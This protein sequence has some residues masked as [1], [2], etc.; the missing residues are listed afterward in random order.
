MQG[1]IEPSVEAALLEYGIVEENGVYGIRI[2]A[3]TSKSTSTK[4]VHG[5]TPD[6]PRAIALM[7]LLWKQGVSPVN[8]EDVLL[9]MGLISS[10]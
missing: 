1:K 3:T 7:G 9:D 10:G 4:T 2:D 5:I 8:L 6:L